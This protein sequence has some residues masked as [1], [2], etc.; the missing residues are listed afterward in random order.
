MIENRK[1]V[2]S[3]RAG[4]LKVEI[5]SNS[6]AAGISAAQ[7]AALMIANIAE[8]H[9]SIGII[10]A[11]GASQINVLRALTEFPGLPW[12][13]VTGFHMDE[14]ENLPR[15]HPASFRRYL[16]ERLVSR[17][18][19]KEFHAID[20]DRNDLRALCSEYAKKLRAAGPR[21]CL[22]GIGENGH[23]AFN[24]PP[25]ADFH[26]PEDV[27]VVVLDEA[28]KQQQVAEGWFNSIEEVPK[29]AVTLTIPALL[30]VPKLIASVPGRRKADIVRRAL[31]EPVSTACPATILRTHPDCTLYLDLDSA[32]KLK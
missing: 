27:K 14:Y 29:R 6:E 32:S 10:F 4:S 16:Q 9:G 3:L 30:R 12:Q 22:L 24:D 7:H 8:A 26:D 15:D 13:R 17:V 25:V 2:E 31:S 18:P 20:A 11:T 1:P 23:L 5:Y 19:M 21:L 28:C